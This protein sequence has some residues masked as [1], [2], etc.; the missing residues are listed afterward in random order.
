MAARA[1]KSP[2]ERRIVDHNEN[3]Q[4]QARIAAARV[5]AQS[6]SKAVSHR[7]E[8]VTSKGGPRQSAVARD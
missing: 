4:G 7:A 6:C 8:D 5:A 2:R 3:G 1:S